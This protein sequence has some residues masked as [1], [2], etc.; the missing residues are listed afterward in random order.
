MRFPPDALAE[1]IVSGVIA[2]DATP[3]TPTSPYPVQP[4]SGAGVVKSNLTADTFVA[5]GSGVEEVKVT[6]WAD[7]TDPGREGLL[8][9]LLNWINVVGADMVE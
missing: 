1:L 6:R 7:C 8:L 4:F 3:N 5:I 9:R 2:A